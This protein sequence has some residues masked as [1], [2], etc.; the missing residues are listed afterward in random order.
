MSNM[1]KRFFFLRLRHQFNQET[2]SQDTDFRVLSVLSMDSLKICTEN[3][4]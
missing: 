2:P 3:L 1:S 4:F